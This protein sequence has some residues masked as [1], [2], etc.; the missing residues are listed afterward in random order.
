MTATRTTI[1]Q[2]SWQITVTMAVSIMLASCGGSDAD[3]SQPPPIAATSAD[4]FS[5]AMY[6][7]GSAWQVTYSGVQKDAV[8]GDRILRTGTAGRVAE[9]PNIFGSSSVAVYSRFGQAGSAESSTWAWLDEVTYYYQLTPDARKKLAYSVAADAQ[10]QRIDRGFFDPVLSV[11]VAQALNVDYS[12]K[13]NVFFDLDSFE[14]DKPTALADAFRE[15][16]EIVPTYVGRETVTVPAGTFETCVFS[17]GTAPIKTWVASAGHFQGLTIQ[18]DN[19]TLL[20]ATAIEAN[21]N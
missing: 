14:G 10:G 7:P 2:A 6:T 13:S 11:P 12:S 15:W 9:G 18:Y 4:C 5:R 8:R 19:G 20:R 1:P 17:R 16:E 21:W 3:E